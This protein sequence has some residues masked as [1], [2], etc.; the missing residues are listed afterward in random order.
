MTVLARIHS[1]FSRIS[2]VEREFDRM[3][4]GTFG[5]IWVLPRV[6]S[7]TGEDM[8]WAPRLELSKKGGDLIARFELPGVDTSDIDVS[9]EDRVL[10]VKGERKAEKVHADEEN[11]YLSESFYG[12][13]ERR[14]E[15]PEGI[16]TESIHAEHSDGI[17]TI[18]IPGGAALEEKAKVSI[19]IET[20]GEAK[21]IE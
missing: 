14:I 4:R 21:R 10:T 8:D 5:D 17:L 9:V 2:L 1:P 20:A 11:L 12:S 13:F 7:L 16:T 15:V 19:P 6:Y 18:R 3:M